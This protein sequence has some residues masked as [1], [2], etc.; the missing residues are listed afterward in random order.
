MAPT[1]SVNET[2]L[3]WLSSP[4]VAVKVAVK[5]K[6]PGVPSWSWRVPAVAQSGPLV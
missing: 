6:L 5:V 3:C 1:L 4:A 2:D